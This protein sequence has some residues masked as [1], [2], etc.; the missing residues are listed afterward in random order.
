MDAVSYLQLTVSLTK[1]NCLS[2]QLQIAVYMKTKKRKR[3]NKWLEEKKT[4]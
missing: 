1:Q 4:K 2:E 3:G